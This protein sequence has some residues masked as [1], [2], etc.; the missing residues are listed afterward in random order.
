M[1]HI[2][3]KEIEQRLRRT[4]AVVEATH[5]ECLELWKTWSSDS[6][7]HSD[8]PHQKVKWEQIS[9]GYWEQIGT[10]QI[11]SARTVF[12]SYERK[13]EFPVCVTMLWARIE[14]QLVMFWEPTS[15]FVDHDMIEAYLNKIM[16]PW[17]TYDRGHRRASTNAM[18]FAHAIDAVME[19]NGT[20]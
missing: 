15:K 4:V 19:A 14:G 10:V 16:D 18:N 12:G 13:G 8:Y 9:S 2:T 5:A 11:K 6:W 20:K 3:D 7:W 17:P 1:S